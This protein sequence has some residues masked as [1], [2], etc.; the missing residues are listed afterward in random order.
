MSNAICTLLLEV[1]LFI[2][3]GSRR[4]IHKVFKVERKDWLWRIWRM[5]V[6]SCVVGTLTNSSCREE[7]YEVRSNH[8]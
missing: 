1:L 3:R 2:R 5:L 8:S 7:R 4:R 6:T